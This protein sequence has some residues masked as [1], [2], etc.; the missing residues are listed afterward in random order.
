MVGVAVRPDLADGEL[1]LVVGFHVE[2]PIHFAH[3][4]CKPVVQL[5]GHGQLHLQGGG[6]AGAEGAQEGVVLEAVQLVGGS[7]VDQLGAVPDLHGQLGQE[8]GH[9]GHGFLLRYLLAEGIARLVVGFRSHVEVDVIAVGGFVGEGDGVGDG[10]TGHDVLEAIEEVGLRVL[11]AGL[12]VEAGGEALKGDGG[13]RKG[14]GG[15][16][17]GQEQGQDQ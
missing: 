14:R 7:V 5:D 6:V 12:E 15:Q 16:A 1:A 13:G 3:P 8:L 4:V 2:D 17:H 10:I 9:G 11:A